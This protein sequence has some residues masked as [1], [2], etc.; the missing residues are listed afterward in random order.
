MTDPG[1]VSEPYWR[2]A[3]RHEL[4]IQRCGSCD[5]P[6]H[7]PRPTCPCCGHRE[8]HWERASGRGRVHT[9]TVARRP[10]HAAF[11]D[12]TPYVI[13]IV[14][15]DEGPRLTTNIVDCDPDSVH[16]GMGV[17]VAFEDRDGRTL[18]VFRPTP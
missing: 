1:P 15:L 3:G 9:F 5:E 4:V 8:L 6:V 17:E 2:A 11:T 16:V 12:R 10:T 18:P 13:A 14:K 7:Y